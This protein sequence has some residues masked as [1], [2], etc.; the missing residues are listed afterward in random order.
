MSIS[1]TCADLID[2]ISAEGSGIRTAHAQPPEQLGVLP[3]AFVVVNRGTVAYQSGD[4]MWSYT[5]DLVVYV[6]PR[7]NNLPAE[8]ARVAPL[9]NSVV[10]TVW[11]AYEGGESFGQT[12]SR[13]VISDFTAGVRDFAG[14]PYHS[15]TFSV[16]VKEH[17]T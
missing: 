8:Y 11:D 15:I 3:A 17:T 6:T 9:I 4:L 7:V 13:C 16:D 14:K 12:V 1:Q 5:L 10:D 2:V